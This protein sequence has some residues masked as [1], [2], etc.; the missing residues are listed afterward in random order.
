MN[1]IRLFKLLIVTILALLVAVPAMAAEWQE[2][3]QRLCSQ[4]QVAGDMSYEEL[5]GM[6]EDCDGLLET[7]KALNN[8][9]NKVYIFRL[10]KC[11][12]FYQYTMDLKDRNG[13]G[14]GT[15][16]KNKSSSA[17]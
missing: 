15:E 3:F 6:L 1:R 8:P 12:N 13:V 2:D 14:A 16:I 10:K 5:T 9:R 7:I 17:E 11:R 4:T